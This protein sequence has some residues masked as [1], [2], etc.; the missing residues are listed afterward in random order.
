MVLDALNVGMLQM[1]RAGAAK[2]KAA[3]MEFISKY[4]LLGFMTALPTTPHFMDY[5][6]AYLPKNHFI[7][8]E[9]M[10]VR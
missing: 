8:E 5:D 7:K 2:V 10:L 6:A 3:V 1:N 4:G 9:S